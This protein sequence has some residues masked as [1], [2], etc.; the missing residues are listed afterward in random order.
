[1]TKKRL[2]GLMANL[3]ILFLV[4]NL[5]GQ[6]VT[7]S[8]WLLNYAQKQNEKYQKERAE[9]ESI[10]IKLGLPIVKIDELGR[11]IELQRFDNG[12]P[13]YYIT[14]N[15]NAAKTI[16]NNKV[17]P[18]GIGGFSLT[19]SSETLGIWDAGRVRLE[20]QEFENRA[21]QKDNAPSNHFHATHVAGTMIAAGID[22]NAK[23]MSYQGNLHAYDW[24]NDESEMATA[25]SNGLQVSNHSYGIITGWYYSDGWHWYGDPSVASSEDYKFGFYSNEA[26]DWDEIARKA[27][28]YLIVKS[29]GNDRLEGPQTQPVTHTH[30]GSGGYTCTHDLDGGPNGYDCISHS[31][32]AKNILT[33]GAV[34]DIP[35][36]YSDSSDVR[37]STFSCWGPTDDGRIKPDIVT[38][39]I[40]LY[41][42]NS[43]SNNSYIT[44]SGTSMSSPNA[45]GSVGLLLQARRNYWGDNPLRASTIKGLIIH[46]ADEAGPYPGPDYMFGWGLMNTLKAVQVIK[47]DSSA[48]GN[49]MIREYIL[50]NA[51]QIEFPAISDGTQPLRVTICW[52]DT[53]GNPPPPSLDPPT[54]MLVN[55]LDLRVISPTKTIYYPWILDPSNPSAP[56]TTGDNIRDNVEQV[57]IATPSAGIYTIRI[58]HKRTL[59]AGPQPVSVILTGIVEAI[60]DISVVAIENPVGVIESTA[61]SVVP[62]VKV[63]NNGNNPDS[64][65]VCLKIDDIYADV[66]TKSLLPGTEDTVNFQEW[67]PIRG[68]FSA[69]CS[70]YLENDIDSSNDTLQVNF[71]VNVRD[72]GTTK[73]T[74]PISPVQYG[75]KL[76]PK[77]WIHNYGS[78]DETTVPVTFYIPNTIYYSTQ[79]VDLAHGDSVEINFDTLFIN[80]AQGTYSMRCT[81]KLHN[82]AVPSNNLASATLTS[83]VPGWALMCTIPTANNRGIKDGGAL[84]VAQDK[85]YALQGGNTPYL[86][87]YDL[88]LNAW[89][90]K[91][92]IPYIEKQGR[93]Y[94]RNVK[95]GGALTALGCTLYAFKGG[96]TSEFWAYLTDNDSWIR[97]TSIPERESLSQTT[98]KVKTGG[99]LV[100]HAC[101]IYAFKGGNTNEFWLYNPVN[102]SWYQRRSLITSDGKKIKGGASLV[103]VGDTIYA[104]VGGNTFHF[105]AYTPDTWVKKANAMFG[106]NY[107][108]SK[109]KIKDG[110]ALS[111]TN[112]GKIYAFKGGNT[113]D[114]GLYDIALDTWFY[115]DTIPGIRRVKYGGSLVSYNYCLYALKG[116]NNSEFWR[117][118]PTI[119]EPS[120]KFQMLN[121]P[122]STKNLKFQNQ[123]T[124]SILTISPN[125]FSKFTTIKYNVPIAGKVTIKLYDAT[126]KLIKTLVEEYH[127]VGT[128][129]CRLNAEHLKKGLYF[130]RIFG[131][132]NNMTM[133][134]TL[135]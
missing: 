71:T 8:E 126:G 73:I 29:A 13:I 78:V 119:T 49:F 58:T 123:N 95:A 80:F 127:D 110:A 90:T 70:V 55:D 117:Y 84:T 81:T 9:A 45:S 114:L 135:P 5:F 6:S 36:G 134:L 89:T 94:K 82:D 52:T 28:Y 44:L 115:V 122:I 88:E 50:N 86:Y 40:G 19:G 21:I 65:H 121:M 99:A 1:M 124:N 128:Y 111:A 35:N 27:P 131:I 76:I 116:G 53:A 20:H 62:C 34:D 75:D 22:T 96:N 105:Y 100:V 113:K 43:I 54:P 39:G 74:A 120:I 15:L 64:F 85:I 12:R 69:R 61:T 104:F 97:K 48:G 77:A 25:A 47:A 107:I 93:I 83:L 129:S 66:R 31:G 11:T 87:Q 108:A 3:F 33:V 133:K 16:S 42:C 26:R 118:T 79:Y 132:I 102:D 57:Y 112:D 72:F 23:G 59:V 56:A 32:V 60:K 68:T 46:T 24:N 41:S 38:N 17:W 92:P 4:V 10:A 130:L 2:I 106:Y 101:S 30:S 91:R 125:P 63:K 109:K 18:S 51:E 103:A 7:H 98:R 37:M 67:I 14:D